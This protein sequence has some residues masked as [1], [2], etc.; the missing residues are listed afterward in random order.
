MKM[1]IPYTSNPYPFKQS[2][3]YFDRW[4]Q[5]IKFLA[6]AFLFYGNTLMHNY[7]SYLLINLG[8]TDQQPGNTQQ[9]NKYIVRAEKLNWNFL[10][11]STH[12]K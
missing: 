5:F 11:N 9:A 1:K 2:K 8:F 4:G 12:D 10:T 7:D 6:S 3:F